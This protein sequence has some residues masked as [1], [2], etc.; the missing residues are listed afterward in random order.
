MAASVAW[1]TVRVTNNTAYATQLVG[2]AV[3]GASWVTDAAPAVSSSFEVT[4]SLL[5]TITKEGATADAYVYAYLSNGKC[6]RVDSA[7]GVSV[8]AAA[9]LA[10]DVAVAAAAGA[11]GTSSGV[12]RL[13]V[14][15]GASGFN[16]EK[17]L[18]IAWADKCTGATRAGVNGSV[19]VQVQ[20]ASP[21]KA[22]LG[23]QHATVA[24]ADD[25]AAS[26]GVPT[27]VALTAQLEFDDG[28]TK[29]MTTDARTVFNITSGGSLAYI[30]G[31]YLYANPG[32]SGSVTV[33]LT[34][35]LTL[36][37]ASLGVQ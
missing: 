25:P 10:A 20:L 15:V 2:S 24:A 31:A 16:D 22:A 34:L 5:Q 37:E 11:T 36:S 12:F 19:A 28:S 29:S 35:R 13:T 9:G 26:V 1:P 27:R 4:V 7:N 8:A 23:T 14:N 17:A 30:S 21:T 33:T 6:L 32:A 3:T 18:Y